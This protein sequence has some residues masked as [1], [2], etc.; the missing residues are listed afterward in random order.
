MRYATGTTVP[1]DRSRGEIE[2]VLTR[3]G[4]DRFAYGWDGGS[5]VIGFRAHGKFLKFVVPIPDKKAEGIALSPRGRRRS[6]G[7]IEQAWDDEC[8]RRWRSLALAIKAKLEMVA[9][10]IS[11]FNVEFLPYIV[12][13]GG[14]TVGNWLAPQIEGIYKSGK[15]PKALPMFA[16]EDAR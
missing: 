9:S 6:T 2:R 10:G 8:R 1:I 15:M 16:G 5:W 13:P 7:V 4:A 3:Y 12:L 14:E 11:E